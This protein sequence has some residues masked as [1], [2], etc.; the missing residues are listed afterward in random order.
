MDK[1]L[2]RSIARLAYLELPRVQDKTGAFV[3]P[4]DH[5]IDDSTLDRY[6]RELGAILDHVAQISKLGADGVEPTSH[7]VP[8][9]TRLRMDEVEGEMPTERALEGAPAKVGSGFS[10]PKVVE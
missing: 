9:P 2:I 1:D 3:E 6:A 7:G 10:V 5:L 8:L 4:E